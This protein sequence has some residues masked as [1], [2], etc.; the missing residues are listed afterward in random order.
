MD[1]KYSTLD[2]QYNDDSMYGDKEVTTGEELPTTKTE[3]EL[4][5]E[6][7]VGIFFPSVPAKA[8]F[9][10]P[11]KK[12]PRKTRKPR[13]ERSSEATRQQK[14]RA[15][16]SRTSQNYDVDFSDDAEIN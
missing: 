8:D 16:K 2:W 5:Y 3:S 7:Q 12:A 10:V 6:E 1:D 15:C 11:E 13:K 14:T 9:K 4:L